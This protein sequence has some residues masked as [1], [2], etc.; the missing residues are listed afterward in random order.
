MIIKIGDRV[1]YSWRFLKSI[2]MS[3]TDMSH[4]K[5]R[6]RELKTLSPDCTLACV[7]WENGVDMP[8]KVNTKNLAIVGPNT[9]YCNCD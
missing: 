7:D 5:G 8:E 9:Q 3:H 6:I 2:G 4:A 1:A